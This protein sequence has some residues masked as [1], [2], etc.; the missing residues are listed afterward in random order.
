MKLELLRVERMLDERARRTVVA[1]VAAVPGV[2]RVR[3]NLADRTLRIEC[4]DDASLA[5]VI[6]AARAAGFS[7]SVFA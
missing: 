7:V 3:A 1:A 6:E 5:A 2:Q 4:D